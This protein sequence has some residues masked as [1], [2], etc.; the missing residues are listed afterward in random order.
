MGSPVAHIEEQVFDYDEPVGPSQAPEGPGAAPGLQQTLAQ[1]LSVHM[2]L[3]Q[4]GMIPVTLVTS[5]PRGRSQTPATRTLEQLARGHLT[6][7]VLPVQQIIAVQPEIMPILTV[8]EQKRLDRFERL[9][10]P[11]FSGEI[12]KDAQ[13]FLDQCHQILCILGLVKSNGVDFT[14]F[15][16]TRPAYRWWQTYG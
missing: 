1:V 14:T 4:A 16:L 11:H 12:T 5:H 6:Q 9:H 3:A 13:G 15:H 7:G 8:E 10:P 2:S